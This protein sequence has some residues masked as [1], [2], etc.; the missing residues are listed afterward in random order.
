[1]GHN[2]L[3]DKRISMQFCVR[4]EAVVF[5]GTLSTVYFKNLFKACKDLGNGNVF[6]R[7]LMISSSTSLFKSCSLMSASSS[8]KLS[9]WSEKKT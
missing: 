2:A 9:G 7:S 5:H 6:N 8:F 1:M 4:S 3:T